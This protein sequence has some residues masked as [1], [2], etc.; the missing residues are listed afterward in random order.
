MVLHQ[1]DNP[2]NQ[3][4]LL[5]VSVIIPIYNGEADLPDLINCLRAQT[6]PA[7]QAEYLLVDNASRDRTADILQAATQDAKSCGLT[8]HHLSENQIQSSY[9]A[10]N[11]GIRAATG[12]ILAFTD[13]DCR[14]Q[15]DWLWALVQ[16]FNDPAVGLVVGAIESLPGSTLLEK[17][18]AN[19]NILSQEDTLA[20]PFC[21]FGQTANLAIRRRTLAQVGLFR[22]H[23]TTGGDA[24]LCW[25]VQQQGAWQLYYT[26]QAIV[27]HRHRATM[28]GLL[29]QWRRYGR[30]VRYWHEL[31]GTDLS[32]EWTL[33]KYLYH[34]SCWLLK[35]LPIASLKA[36]TGK[37]TLLELL[38]T[39]IT[40]LTVQAEAAGQKEANLPEQARQLEWLSSSQTID[41]DSTVSPVALQN[42]FDEIKA[43]PR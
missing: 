2:T 1:I 30:A 12:E 34:L 19:P 6:Y 5:N 14:P 37:A 38:R 7:E 26:K 27:L 35:E 36:I 18:A 25:R 8:I 10:R 22:G 23:L 17:Y 29:S 41:L 21:P 42:H 20:H 43:L 15:P 40:L 3:T 24:D 31:Y 28:Q 32:P 9:A 33:Q 4:F 16:S 39:P 11:T 13:V